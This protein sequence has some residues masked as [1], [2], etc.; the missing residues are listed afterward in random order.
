MARKPS[1]P[2]G[3]SVAATRRTAFWLKVASVIAA[4]VAFLLW[5]GCTALSPASN[6][7]DGNPASQPHPAVNAFDGQ[8]AFDL[9][10]QQ[11]N[12]G[13]RIP[14]TEPS[15]QTQQLI[16]QK[17]QEAGAQVLRQEFTVTYRGATY[18]M[19]NVLGVLKGRSDRK[20]LLCAHYDTRPVADQDPNPANRNKPIP[21]ANDGASGVAVLLE[22][23]RVLKTHQP[24][25]TVVF[26]FFDGEDL[27]DVSDGGM[28][29]GSKFFARNLTVN[30]VNLRAE[31]G[32]LLD[33][34]GDRD[35]RSTD[36]TFSRQFAPQVV[37]GILRA[38]K[39]LGYGGLFFQPPA[40]SIM[41][42][43]LP[44]NEAGIPTADIIDFDY[45]YWHTL[46]DTP[47]KCSAETLAIVGRTVLQWLMTL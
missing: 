34:V 9:L 29:F 32:V 47:D 17:L 7:N 33:M 21:G 40:M 16:T 1:H 4:F 25:R 10:V 37:D 15:R 27:G 31:M 44:L 3:Q 35:F 42:D 13:P 39:V 30:G 19:V 28:F 11:V 26:A 6:S 14:D 5:R 46:Q 38:A 20:V 22:I 23:A 18:R 2:E 36:E 41:D 45:P 12:F 24:P 8:R 43:H